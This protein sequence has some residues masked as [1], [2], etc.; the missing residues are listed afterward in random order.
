MPSANPAPLPPSRLV[1]NGNAEGVAREPPDGQE[2]DLF[3][4]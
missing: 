3:V 2:D 1:A 4:P